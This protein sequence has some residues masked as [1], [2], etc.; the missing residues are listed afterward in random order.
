[1]DDLHDK[2]SGCLL[3][4]AYGDAL[5]APVEFLNLDQIVEQLGPYGIGKLQTGKSGMAEFTDDTQM[6]LFTAEG[7][8]R[9]FTRSQVRG[10]ASIPSVVHASY[11][12][13]LLTQNYKSSILTEDDL[14]SYLMGYPELFHRRAPGLTCISS[15]QNAE[16][17]GQPARNDSKGNGAVMR[18]A[19]VGLIMAAN[20]ESHQQTFDI[21]YD[22][23]GL[24]H[25]HETGKVSAA[26][27]ALLIHMIIVAE[28][29]FQ[30][31]V[32][33]ALEWLRN[34]QQDTVNGRTGL[35]KEACN[36]TLLAV[37]RAASLAKDVIASGEK[38]SCIPME[39]GEGWVAEEAVAI[40]VFS[41]LV[42]GNPF[43]AVKLAVNF[44]GDSDSTGSMTG[45]LLGARHGLDALG[46]KKTFHSI[47]L[48]ALIDDIAYDLAT[49]QSWPISDFHS[50]FSE[51]SDSLTERTEIEA[52][53]DK[54]PPL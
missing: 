14:K 3:L 6:T 49:C 26:F 19:P 11:L 44:S 36:E 31:T 43:S 45:H 22:I 38:P 50:P 53:L 27:F 30:S 54:Y 51:A 41:A 24:T 10:G 5:G 23:A 39:L 28:T 9:A 17:F 35:P 29:E 2:F 33:Q 52:V 25:G 21:A 4:G 8:L 15:L 42:E 20:R 1:M 7:I 32:A 16:S 13:W 46:G 48:S 12:R 40:A 37:S 47:E 34:Y 18:I